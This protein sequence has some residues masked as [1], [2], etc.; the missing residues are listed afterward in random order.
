MTGGTLGLLIGQMG[1][2]RTDIDP[3]TAALY[4]DPVFK[5]FYCSESLIMSLIQ[6]PLCVLST[7]APAFR[8]REEG[9]THKN[10]V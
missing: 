1:L 8:G 6:L 10:S 5:A 3:S 2:A 9:A 7:G 4:F